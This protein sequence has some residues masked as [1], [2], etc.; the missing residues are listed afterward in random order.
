MSGDDTPTRF[1][2]CKVGFLPPEIQPLIDEATA[3]GFG[4]AARLITHW[5][6]GENR[7]ERPGELFLLAFVDA[8]AVGFG[9]LNVDPYHDSPS[10]GRVRHIYVENASRKLGVGR[11]IVEHVIECARPGFDRLRLVTRQAAPFYERLGFTL[12]AERNAT[13]EMWL[14]RDRVG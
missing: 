4:F 2:L 11:A 13:H 9:G 1:E 6:S 14:R 12:V 5:A 7:F 3:E 10:V 8:R